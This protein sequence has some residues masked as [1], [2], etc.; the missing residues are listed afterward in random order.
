MTTNSRARIEIIIR[1]GLDYEVHRLAVPVSEYLLRE[2]S[3]PMELSDNPISLFIAGGHRGRDVVE[4]RR[5]KFLM[6]DATANEISKA[7]TNALV[8]YFCRNDRM[9]GYTKEE[10]SRM[11]SKEDSH[12]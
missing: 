12:D 2:L 11:T 8:E 7:L 3:E 6:R 4:V 10:T 5:K 9:D 1:T